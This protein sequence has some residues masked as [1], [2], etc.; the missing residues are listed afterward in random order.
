VLEP[1]AHAGLGDG[2]GDARR[3]DAG[4]VVLHAEAL[5]DDVGVEPLD[6]AEPLQPL[7]EDGDLLVAVHAFDAEHRFGVKLAD[8]AGHAGSSTWVWACPSSSMM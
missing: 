8:F 1:G 2:L 6:A 4:G 5:A 3:R 7:L